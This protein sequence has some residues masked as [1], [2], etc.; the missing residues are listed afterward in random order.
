M[1][2]MKPTFIDNEA[3]QAELDATEWVE[4]VEKGKDYP[5][6]EGVEFYIEFNKPEGG[7]PM[8]TLSSYFPVVG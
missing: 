1:R 2:R 4:N 3:C 5:M 7:A 6:N 8:L